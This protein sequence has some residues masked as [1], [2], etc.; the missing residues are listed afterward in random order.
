M[1]D[2]TGTVSRTLRQMISLSR[3]RHCDAFRNEIQSH[4]LSITLILHGADIDLSLRTQQSL[5][6]WLSSYE[7]SLHHG[8]RVNESHLIGSNDGSSEPIRIAAAD[9]YDVLS[10][11]LEEYSAALSRNLRESQVVHLESNNVLA[12]KMLGITQA[13]NRQNTKRQR[14]A[15]HIIRTT[16]RILHHIEATRLKSRPT[17]LVS[18]RT[19]QASTQIH[20]EPTVTLLIQDISEVGSNLLVILLRIARSLFRYHIIRSLSSQYYD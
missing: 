6:R 12:D 10:P 17:D 15:D 5:L 4:I 2:S 13:M 16:T 8:R 1:A 20:V 11:K 9:P 3:Q 18:S 19:L 14:E 7:Q